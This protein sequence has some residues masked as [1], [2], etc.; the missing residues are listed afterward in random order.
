MKVK[1]IKTFKDAVT[2]EIHQVGS[3]IDVTKER[4]DAILSKGNYIEITKT[5][6]KTKKEEVAE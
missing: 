1:V 6:K 4:A 3:M 2:G 5:N